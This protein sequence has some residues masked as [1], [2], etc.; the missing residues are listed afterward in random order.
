VNLF[1][2]KPSDSKTETKSRSQLGEAQKDLGLPPKGTYILFYLQA[3]HIKIIGHE[4]I[5]FLLLQLQ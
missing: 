5:Y 3:D 2:A 1:R 4:L